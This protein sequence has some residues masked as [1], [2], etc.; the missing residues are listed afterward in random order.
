M[1]RFFGIIVTGDSLNRKVTKAAKENHEEH[2][3]LQGKLTA[4]W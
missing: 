4:E 1:R 3:L 2:K